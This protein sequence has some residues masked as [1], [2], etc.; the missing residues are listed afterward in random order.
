MISEALVALV[1]CPRCPADGAATPR[2]RPCDGGAVL[3]CP[4]CGA[5]YPQP[6]GGYLDLRPPAPPG[7][8]ET[9]YSAEAGEF[10]AALAYRS[11][12]VPLL[13]AAVRERW[14]RRWLPLGPG[15]LVLDAGCGDGR[16]ALWNG[17]SGARIVGLDAAPLF[18]DAALDAVDL[19]RGD[20]RALPFPTAC[21]D[22]VYSIDVME[23]LDAHGLEGYFAEIA[24][25]L[26][27]GGLC[28]LY[29]NTRERATLWPV[30]EGWGRVSRWL[31]GRGVGD[32]RA[33]DLRK[34]DHVKVLTTFEQVAGFAAYHGLRVERVRFWN[35]VF[36]GLIDNVLVRLGEALLLRR[37][38]WS[39]E[40]GA[41]SVERE[42]VEHESE[43]EDTDALRS[44]L[45]AP[46][47]TARQDVAR[48][49]A[50]RLALRALTA[51]M[52]L[53]VILFGRLRS[54]PFF[55]LLRREKP[56]R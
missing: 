13:G 45:Y 24:R 31:R 5:R 54:G 39:V 11:V 53:D 34:S 16:F 19:V 50:A 47:S 43:S 14:L 37:G 29:S 35:G 42:S 33:D 48:R 8:R 26:K 55:A 25:V 52:Q 1:T 44:T 3:L 32:F 51:L 22:A 4:R 9:L 7:G 20:L 30:V 15:R 2:L 21:F 10:A 49:P 36:Q 38:A 56:R 18:A 40:R 6:G 17:G 28:Y 46:R 27:P 23:H 12:G 41:W